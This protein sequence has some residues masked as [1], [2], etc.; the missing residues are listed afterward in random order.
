MASVKSS[1]RSR[2]IVPPS[3]APP[4]ANARS[5]YDAY[6]DEQDR[7][8]GKRDVDPR[9][10]VDPY[11]GQSV[12][13]K[14][15]RMICEEL[16]DFQK[17]HQDE[18]R[19]I[20]YQNYT[21]FIRTSKEISELEEEITAM[22]S[23]LQSQAALIR[24]LA[25]SGASL[26]IGT[27]GESLEKDYYK[28][29]V[30]PTEAVKRAELLPDTLDVLLAERKVEDAL[31]LLD[32]GEGLVADFF[33]GIGAEDLSEG[34]IRQLE[35][36]LAERKA[37][38]A[39]Y[40]AEAVQQP[41]VRGLELRS[42]ISALDRLG[43]GSRAHTLLLHSHEE[44]LKHNM[45]ALRQSGASYGGVYTTAISQLVFS[46]IAQASRD[47]VAVFGEV[48]SYAS[49]LVLWASDVTE[50]CA[51][52]IKRNVLLSS[53]AAG[54]LRAAVEC[55]QIAL[56]HCAL[57]E[58]RG[59]TLCPT[60]SKL[61]RP[62]V[63]QALKA[64]LT[65]IIDSVGSLASAENWTLDIQRGTRGS[66]SNLRLSTSGHRFLY[67]VQDFLE[68]LP[69]LV[70]IQLGGAALDGIAGV[71]EQYMDMLVKALPG[72]EGE[73]EGKRKVRIAA[74]EEQQLSLLGNATALADE[75]TAVA[76]SKILPGG[77]QVLAGELKAPRGSAASA[78]SPEL[79][80]LRRQ[81]QIHVE[82]LKFYLCNGIIIGL[83]YDEYGSKLNA[84]TYFQIDSE[85]PNWEDDPLPTILFQSVFDKLFS[86]QQIAG[87][88]LCGRDRVTQLLL[89]RL[90]ETFVK[91]LSTNP[92]LWELLK[93]EPGNLG[94]LGL[95]QFIL[96]M[97]FL[98][99]VAKNM[100]F[101]SRTVFQ[102]ITQEEERMKEAYA[103]GG[104]D[105]DSALP[106]P[107]WLQMSVYNNFN[108]LVDQWKGNSGYVPR[109]AS[110]T[111]SMSSMRSE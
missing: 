61:I 93:E 3:R 49:E 22:N 15:M 34:V 45:N 8:S 37:G 2:T 71:F 110:D 79:K 16:M 87:D 40:L 39:A 58:E 105:L 78:R 32:E 47:S 66:G 111:Q 29:D 107:G 89:I 97:E 84:T 109:D 44:R 108:N 55:V 27:P 77:L 18:M 62:S 90:T 100:G 52:V 26:P 102:A 65:S 70:S 75:I 4:Q 9:S 23:M 68:D 63:E 59:L 53:A 99:L 72:Q 35:K 50:M 38:L 98:S 101:L 92:E 56:G 91:D 67:L 13:E 106:D 41:T 86:I 73:E 17:I 76:A 81:L 54:G 88:V 10:L 36:A 57:L 25:E 103:V 46:A 11:K 96:D 82:K 21:M 5:T 48:P 85:Q 64:N 42:A 94:P 60:L 43:D 1:M 14:G 30:E 28:H 80:D 31:A 69:P 12:G 20:V 7:T 51:S 95:K 24:T 74:S 6:R 104:A 33:N 83:C 19:K